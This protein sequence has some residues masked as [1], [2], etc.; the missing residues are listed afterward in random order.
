MPL[1]KTLTSNE[2][3]AQLQNHIAHDKGVD[4]WRASVTQILATQTEILNALREDFKHHEEKEEHY[5]EK[6]ALFMQN[7]SVDR[8]IMKEK[9]GEQDKTII[10]LTEHHKTAMT[11]MTS[12]N[13]KVWLAVGAVAVYGPILSFLA[14]ELYRHLTGH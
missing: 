12:I 8:A 4:E 13:A 14:V 3:T 10:T 1:K 5:Q 2:L 11:M 7:S 6:V 9:T